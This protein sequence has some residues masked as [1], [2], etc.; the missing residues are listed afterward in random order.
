[1][2]KIQYSFT[3]SNVFPCSLIYIVLSQP[4]V[5]FGPE[6]CFPN[7]LRGVSHKYR[8][9][10]DKDLYVTTNF[11]VMKL[12]SWFGIVGL[13]HNENHLLDAWFSGFVS[14]Q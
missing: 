14:K 10:I 3:A 7:I 1:M 4:R 2:G 12:L 13:P 11:S 6:C 8:F 5:S 9:H